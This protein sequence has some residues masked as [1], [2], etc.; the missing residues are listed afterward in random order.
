MFMTMKN[1]QRGLVAIKIV[2]LSVV[3]MFTSSLYAQDDQPTENVTI[4]VENATIKSVLDYIEESNGYLFFFSKGVLDL[5]RKVTLNFTDVHIS[6]VLDSMLKGTDV[7]YEIK[8]NQVSFKKMVLPPPSSEKNSVKKDR[9]RL[10]GTVTD[11]VTEEPLVGVT[12]QIAGTYDGTTTDIDGNY[13]IDLPKKKTD[14]VVSC[15]GYKT[16]ELAVGDLG[17][18]NIRMEGD[19]EMLDGVVVIG[20]G[21]QK[22][23]TV[24]GSISTIKGDVL[25]APS[26]SLTSSFA[27]KLA[28][29]VAATHS[30]EPGAASEF[31]IRGVS[32]FG[33]RATPLILLDDVEISS[34]DLN[35]IPAES[36]ESFSILKDAS[37]TA[38]YGARG[39]NGVMIITTKKGEENT[40]AKINVTLENSYFRPVNRVEYVDG[41]RWMTIYNEAELTRTPTATPKYSQS[42]IENTANNINKYV[43]PNV[44]WYDEIF[45]DFN[46]SQRANINLQGGGSKVTYYMGLQA[47]HDTGL[48]DVP[49]TSSLSTNINNWNYVFQSNL[50]YRPTSTTTVDLH[51]NAQFGILKGPGVST[52]EL[53]N[54][55]YNSNPVSFPKMFPAEEGDEHI[56][57]GNSI[58]SDSRLNVNP[59]A[60]MLS[61]FKQTNFSTIN[62]SLKIVQEL[63]FITKGLS[64][65]ALVNMKAFSSSDYKNTISPY[66]Y[67]VKPNSWFEEFPDQFLTNI[68]ETGSDYINQGGINRY[69]DQTFYLDTRINYARRFGDHYVSAMVMYMMRDYRNAVLPNRNQGVSGRATY[70]FANRYLAEFNFGYNGTERLEKGSRFEFFPAVSLGWVVSNEP[71]WLP[72]REAISHLKLRASYGLVGSD[73]TGLAAGASHFLYKNTVSMSHGDSWATGPTGNQCLVY[74]GPAVLQYAIEN[75]SWER[76]KKLDVGIDFHLY[77]QLFL[78]V[79]YFH[80]LRDRIL[81]VRS[82]FPS[83]LG[84]GSAVPWSNIGVVENEGVEISATWKKELIPGM[85]VDLRGNFTMTRNKYVYID[86]PDYPYTWKKQ[87]G[88]PLHATYGYKAIGLF[89]DEEDIATSAS[90]SNLGSVMPGDIKYL[91]RNGDGM[92]TSDDQMLLSPYGAFPGIQY[93]FGMNWSYKNFD[94][95]VFFTGSA[96]RTIMI[97]NIAPFC[98]DDGNNDRNLMKFIA[99]NYWSESNPNPDA[100]YPRLGVTNKQI[101]NN[102]VASSFWLRDGSFLRF[103]TLEFGYSFKI[104]RVYLS[105]DNI[106]VW[107]PFKLWDPELSYSAYPLQRTFNL[108]VQFKL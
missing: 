79:D 62:T 38:I 81:M 103:K 4:K 44:D 15:L 30:G 37:A 69:T 106:A 22:K 21:T 48:L 12:I 35:R 68:L 104:A 99:D 52:T 80:E 82:S 93:G 97:N 51:L 98:T 25:R 10:V 20:A 41:V 92:I 6:V 78:T 26:S 17:V 108:G 57:F 29:V 24:T 77:N 40:R 1:H 34:A 102:K 100:A 31:Y 74:T 32:T 23:V 9:R 96:N 8:G 94:F 19:N 3:L 107:S 88:N 67:Q 18:L 11:A 5:N 13:V 83:M 47:N 101:A 46:M 27:G 59:Y 63:D 89:K 75:G 91:D 58:Q 66:Y 86:E 43:Y 70:D 49:K 39:A 65:S 28:G 36:I 14:I 50:S 71:F 84:Y 53:F 90:Q 95:G 73:E 16:Q 54:N 2:V 60:R 55:V 85:Y 33:G 76:S 64:A 45:R 61:S 7:D 56:R 87:T 42:Y 72:V 105:G